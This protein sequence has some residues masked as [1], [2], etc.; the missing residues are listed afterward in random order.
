MRIYVYSKN[1]KHMKF[2][3]KYNIMLA[4]MPEYI[5]IYQD[6]KLLTVIP[7]FIHSFILILESKTASRARAFSLPNISSNSMLLELEFEAHN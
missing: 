5:D 3:K 1:S 7:G 2:Y 6:N 4:S